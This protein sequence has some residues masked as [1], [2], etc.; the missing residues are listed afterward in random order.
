MSQMYIFEP[1][2]TATTRKNKSA[3]IKTISSNYMMMM[4]FRNRNIHILCRVLLY[5]QFMIFIYMFIHFQKIIQI[6]DIS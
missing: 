1:Y 4:I 2:D 5:S 3:D 6:K